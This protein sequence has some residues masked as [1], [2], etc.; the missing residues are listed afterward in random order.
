M[1]DHDSGYKLLFAHPEMV[2]DLI[3]E[4]VPGDWQS[5]IDFSTLERI[6][7]S[8]VSDEGKARQDGG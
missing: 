1:T 8:F 3:L 5:L 4:F 7:A 2:R 6:N